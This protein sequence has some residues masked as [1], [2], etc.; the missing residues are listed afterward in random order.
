MATKRRNSK[1]RWAHCR[2]RKNNGGARTFRKQTRVVLVV[3]LL[4]GGSISGVA[5]DF[6]EKRAQPDP[7]WLAFRLLVPLT[8]R[9]RELYSLDTCVWLNR[10]LSYTA[11][12][13]KMIEPSSV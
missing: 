7:G 3:G 1:Y 4:F 2:S 8:L 11:Q 9:T 13:H 12:V 10:G 6:E 5:L